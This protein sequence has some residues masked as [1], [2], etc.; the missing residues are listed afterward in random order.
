MNL[1]DLH[2]HSHHSDGTDDISALVKSAHTVGLKA[3]AL[4]DHDTVAGVNDAIKEAQQ[5][6]IEVIPGTELSVTCDYGPRKNREIHILGLFVDQNNDYF[7]TMLDTIAKSR[8][9]R[10]EQMIKLLNEQGFDFTLDELYEHFPN[11]IITRA[12]F[13]RM[14]VDK[15]YVSD[16]P[17]AFD[18][19]IGDGC[20]CYVKR[21]HLSP[22]DAINLIHEA[23]GIA[24]LAHPFL[25]KLERNDIKALI[26]H[27]K[28]LG[29]D[30]VEAIYSTH[31]PSDEIF[32]RTVVKELELV[33]TGGSDYHG[34]NKPHI[35][36]GIGRGGLKIGEHI[37][38]NIKE[39]FFN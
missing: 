3:F 24:V 29:L 34:S 14:L 39:R 25:Y 8:D 15:G 22:R 5:Y 20:C 30:G 17:K 9:I 6:N 28:N 38:D 16:I 23:G 32:L 11:A 35:K 37:L 33:Y 21:E 36:L 26:A 7:L 1:I 18:R 31:S 12:H 2:V 4:T 27:L 10:N 19:Y 13:A